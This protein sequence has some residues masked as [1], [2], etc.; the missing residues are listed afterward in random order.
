MCADSKLGSTERCPPEKQCSKR[1]PPLSKW[2]ETFK[3]EE[4]QE[5]ARI[6]RVQA[7]GTIRDHDPATYFHWRLS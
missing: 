2:G 3:K 5:M 6:G 1:V 7:P 4:K